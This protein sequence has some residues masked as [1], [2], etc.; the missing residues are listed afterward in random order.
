MKHLFLVTT[1]AAALLTGQSVDVESAV[2]VN[3]YATVSV[4]PLT[5]IWSNVLPISS[6]I[7][8][9]PLGR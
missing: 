8:E 2:M 4:A 1:I 9:N 5:G 3:G 7:N 6:Q